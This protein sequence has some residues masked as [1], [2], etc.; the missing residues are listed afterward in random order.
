MRRK[1]ILFALM[2][3]LAYALW[4]QPREV[5]GTVSDSR[6]PLIGVSVRVVGANAVSITDRNGE[7]RIMAREGDQLEFSYIGYQTLTLQLDQRRILEI[8][9][10]EDSLVL[11]EVVVVGYGTMRKS[12]VTGAI[13]SIRENEIR[14]VPVANINQALQ[15]RLA[16]VQVNQTSTRPGQTGQIRIRGSR[17][18]N[19]SN[20]PLIVV[21][22]IPFDGSMNDLN[23][24]D[25][26]GVDVLKDASAT[27]IYGARGANGVILI[28]TNRGQ[29]G[30]PK[31]SYSG[32]GGVKEV[33]RKYKV[34][35]AE[36]FIK[37]RQIAGAFTNMPQEDAFYATGD[38]TNW[39]D[40]MYQPGYVTQHD[41]N[42]SGGTDN[43]VYSAGGGYYKESTILPGQDFSRIS[44][45]ASVDT[46]LGKYIR[47]GMSTQNGYTVTNGESASF[48][49]QL[50]TLSP[51]AP[52]YDD[53]GNPVLQPVYPN[54]NYYNP[55]L[56]LNE[57]SWA[58]QRIRFNS[59]NTLFG[60]VN[61]TP[62]FRY[63]LNVG[64]N[65]RQDNYGHFYGSERPFQDGES[66]E[67]VVRNGLGL[68]WT[69]EHLLY[70][71][72]TF[73]DRHKLNLTALFSMQE[74]KSFHSY[75]KAMDMV[76]DYV[77][78]FNL[79]L[80]NADK[81][82]IQVPAN[83]QG[84]YRTALMSGMFRL[85][86]GFDNRY[87]LTATI[88]ADGASVLSE[89]RKF[90]YYPAVSVAWNI[91]NEPFMKGVDAVSMLKIR[92]GYGQTANQSINAYSTLGGLSQN[93]Y[94]FGDAFAFGYYVSSLANSDLGWEYTNTFNIGLD[95]G[96][97]GDR[98]TGSIEWY[99]QHTYDLLLSQSLPPTSGVP[100]SIM[101]NV[102]ETQNKGM[103]FTLSGKIV[104]NP[105]TGFNWTLDANVFFNRNKIIALNQVEKDEGNGWFVGYPIDVIYDY[106]KVGIWQIAE[107]DEAALYGSRPGEVKILDYDGNGS[108]TTEDRHIYGTFEP[109]FEGGFTSRMN[110]KN[111]DF[112]I[113][114]FFRVGGTLVS[115]IYQGQSYLNMLQGRRNNIW[116]DYWTPTNPTNEY[117]L[118]DA[119]DR[120]TQG[121]YNSVF[122]YY[123]AS[124]L[125]IR[126][127]TLG[128]TLPASWLR[129]I[130]AS[131]V[132]IYLTA[133]NPF[134][135]FS[136]YLKAGGV[137]PEA[138]GSGHQGFG[139]SG[140]IQS[141]QLT[142]GLNTPPTRN[143]LIGINIG[144]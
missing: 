63:R 134:T 8:L 89:G 59:F 61:F 48:M 136:P 84:Y 79:G 140:P 113:V 70:F 3:C 28:T 54:D 55:L 143:Y 142:I 82:S 41:L 105:G 133:Q 78:Y 125:K 49:Y 85:N 39:Q 23:T 83:Q 130:S 71:D 53:E 106:K 68:G 58:Q 5:S 50:V 31:V 118:P 114:G 62:D 16:G 93:K 87:M 74:N 100:G 17:S 40:L 15:G 72:K 90:H 139:Y 88:R 2:M 103:E 57:N 51:I 115:T 77:Q 56:V 32:F 132:R 60:E 52:A 46:K 124:F 69:M 64:L 73:A 25:I 91:A 14:E 29:A 99:Q 110:Y 95:F 131:Q 109:K 26:T 96:I 116:V 76:A 122:G 94:N 128:Y 112:S 67:A 21:D 144:F 66:S 123:D 34:F 20:D 44:L 38:E 75:M 126:T 101:K 45:R 1:T 11:E 81:G 137:D 107:A 119:T 10:E 43:A 9:M 80:Y 117:P 35:D 37:L 24:G 141:R 98:L 18:L 6:G 129:K 13:S 121:T 33:A 22:G 4:A 12:D 108:I 104:D 97:F 47:L 42:V 19:A 120:P 135:L 27:A 111:F 36:E 92:A 7:F 127:I 65:Y 30:K 138:T 102:G 86:Y